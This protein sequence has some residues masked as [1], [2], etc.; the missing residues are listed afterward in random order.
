MVAVFRENTTMK[1]KGTHG[2]LPADV[3]VGLRIRQ[4]RMWLGMSQTE[5]GEALNVTFQQIQKYERGRNRVSASALIMIA[6]KLEVSPATLL[7]AESRSAEVVV[8]ADILN[9]LGAFG[10]VQ[11]I[12]DYAILTRAERNVVRQV[13]SALSRTHRRDKQTA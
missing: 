13:A 1:P 12:A 5:L 3:L 11:L 4:R 6:K 10:A 7:G 2:P 8:D 9:H